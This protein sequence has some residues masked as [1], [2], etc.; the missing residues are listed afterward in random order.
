MPAERRRKKLEPGKDSRSLSRANELSSQRQ[1]PI[2]RY[3]TSFLTNCESLS[4]VVRNI[5]Q[6]LRLTS[7]TSNG[8][9]TCE[10]QFSRWPCVRC[11]PVR[12]SVSPTR[13]RAAQ[14]ERVL[15]PARVPAPVRALEEPA[16]RPVTDR[17]AARAAWAAVLVM[18]VPDPTQVLLA[19]AGPAAVR[20]APRIFVPAGATIPPVA[21]ILVS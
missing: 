4:S 19:V 18:R 10:R 21:D 16:R 17:A 7:T 2:R 3:T 6:H 8:V 1:A 5:L 12:R 13:R 14:V 9:E 15:E 11:L 20:V